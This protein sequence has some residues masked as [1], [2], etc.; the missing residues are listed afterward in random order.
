MKK[1]LVVLSLAMAA[2]SF[3]ASAAALAWVDII[4]DQDNVIDAQHVSDVTPTGGLSAAA[5]FIIEADGKVEDLW[6]F[7]N[8]FVG[9]FKVDVWSTGFEDK[10]WLSAVDMYDD[11]SSMFGI[12]T[13][14]E[15]NHWQLIANFGADTFNYLLLHGSNGIGDDDVALGYHGYTITIEPQIATPIPAAIWLFGSA[16]MGLTGISRRKKVQA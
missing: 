2:F 16:L 6:V 12:F 7:S 14:V 4:S 3:Q 15:N 13:E 1:V 11:T 8:E 9:N 5:S 10:N